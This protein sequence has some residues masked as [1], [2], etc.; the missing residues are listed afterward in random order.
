MHLHWNTKN[1]VT[2][3]YQALVVQKLDRA[4]HCLNKICYPV[5]LYYEN[6]LCYPLDRDSTYPSFEQLG[7]DEKVNQANQLEYEQIKHLTW[8]IVT[9]KPAY[10]GHSWEMER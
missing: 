3:V 9:V 6:Q 8:F 5:D 10:N 4:I 1:K 2:V 7:P